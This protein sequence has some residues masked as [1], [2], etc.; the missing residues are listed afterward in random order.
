[1]KVVAAAIIRREG[2]ILVA[3]RAVGQ[4]LAGMWEFPGGKLEPTETPQTCIVRELR[5]ELGVEATAG[6]VV[7]ESVFEYPGGVIRLI[8][9]EV[10][11][12]TCDFRLTVHDAF[13]WFEP[14]QLLTIALAPADVPIAEELI[15]R[16][17]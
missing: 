16:H 6:E 2:R 3:R 7:A 4:S 15:R 17:G 11:L 13:E 1:M 9:V 10:E 12:E 8:G 5:E 14:A